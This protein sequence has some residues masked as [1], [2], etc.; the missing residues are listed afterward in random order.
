MNMKV[1]EADLI[2]RKRAEAACAID[3][4]NAVIAYCEMTKDRVKDVEYNAK[5]RDFVKAIAA[6]LSEKYSD[7]RSYM[8]KSCKKV[9]LIATIVKVCDRTIDIENERM[10]NTLA[11]LEKIK[12]REK[13]HAIYES[14]R[15]LVDRVMP[16]E[17][18]Y[19]K[20]SDNARKAIREWDCLIGCIESGHI[21]EENLH[22]YGIDLSVPAE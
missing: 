3:G 8:L 7:F 19:I 22:E 2:A 13:E 20:S 6:E 17:N 11:S 14:R 16:Y 1:T 15:A 10:A 12:E 21:T 9:D 5:T 4:H 18:E